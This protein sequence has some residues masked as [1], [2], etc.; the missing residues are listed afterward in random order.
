[1]RRWRMKATHRVDVLSRDAAE[2]FLV[3]S[4]LVT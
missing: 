4:M 2:M 1:M 3:V